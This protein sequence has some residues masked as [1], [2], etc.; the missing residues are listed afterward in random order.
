M[1]GMVGGIK[2]RKL[3]VQ[4]RKAAASAAATAAAF[5]PVSFP[6]GV[7]TSSTPTSRRRPLSRPWNGGG[8]SG[9]GS[10]KEI[11]RPSPAEAAGCPATDEAAAEERSAEE[12]E[13]EE[14]EEACPAPAPPRKRDLKKLVDG[15]GPLGLGQRVEAGFAGGEDLYPGTIVRVR[16]CSGG[17]WGCT[18]D[19]AYDDGDSE[20]HVRTRG[21]SFF[22]WASLE[23]ARSFPRVIFHALTFADVAPRCL[24]A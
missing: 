17:Q 14:E 23:R 2:V 24:P 8:G 9:G 1:V 13:S 15:G 16:G 12:A 18:Y 5:P 10:L 21:R 7:M 19:V 6:L 3:A 11:D 20:L 22:F 4:L